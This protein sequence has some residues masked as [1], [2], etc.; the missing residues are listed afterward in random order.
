MFIVFNT[1]IIL[2]NSRLEMRK[3]EAKIFDKKKR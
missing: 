3:L 2:A 1:K